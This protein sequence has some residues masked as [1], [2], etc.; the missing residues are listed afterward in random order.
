[1]LHQ[2]AFSHDVPAYHANTLIRRAFPSRQRFLISPLLPLGVA[3]CPL[4]KPGQLV[5]ASWIAIDLS[6]S[7]ELRHIRKTFSKADPV[8]HWK[9]PEKTINPTKAVNRNKSNSS[10]HSGAT[11]RMSKSKNGLS[12]F[13]IF[14]RSK[15]IQL[16]DD[17][18]MMSYGNG[19]IFCR[20][21]P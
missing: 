20:K 3:H 17:S 14:A 16:G 2:A 12:D 10:Q 13:K 1:M 9:H 5:P 4:S 6:I 7:N 19:T 21:S 18:I 11:D 15:G 8:V